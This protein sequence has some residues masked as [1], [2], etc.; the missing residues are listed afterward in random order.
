MR[1][2]YNFSQPLLDSQTFRTGYLIFKKNNTSSHLR[3]DF[4]TIKE[5]NE[6]TQKYIEHII[7]DGIW[8]THIDYQ[9]EHVKK[10]QQAEPNNPIDAFELARQHFPIIGFTK[11]PELKNNS[12][13]H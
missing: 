10:I 13:Y 4:D 1:F 8:L 6:K 3:I 9:T 5:D 7:F 12:I 2:E 11:I